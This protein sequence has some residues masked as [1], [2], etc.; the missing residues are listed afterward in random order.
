MFSRYPTASFSVL[1]VDFDAMIILLNWGG[2]Q[3]LGEIK[4][5]PHSKGLFFLV[6]YF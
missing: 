4:K 5:R 2:S 1:E 6:D 3:E